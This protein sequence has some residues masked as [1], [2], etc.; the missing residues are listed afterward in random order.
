MPDAE[1]IP[2][3]TRQT[4][5]PRRT[6]KRPTNPTPRGLTIP[7]ARESWELALTSRG[8]SAGTINSYAE[9]LQIFVRWAG[10]HDLCY[11]PSWDPDDGK[12]DCPA[13]RDGRP[14]GDVPTVEAVTAEHVRT[15]LIHE[16]LRTSAG[17]AHKH[18]RNLRAF[19]NWLIK[20]SHVG[21]PG[22]VDADDAPNPGKREFLPL[23]D[24]EVSKLLKACKGSDFEARRDL[25]IIR[26]L[27]D[28]GPRL[29]GLVG[30]R[31]T[32]DDK[33][34]HDVQLGQYRIRI[35]LKGGDEY[36]A[37]IGRKAAADIDRY[38]RTARAAHADAD[39]PW[40]WLGQRG[41][42]G[43]T[44]VHKMLKRR[45][46][47]AGVEDVH[48]HRFRRTSSTMF[49]DAG[50]SETDAMHVYGWKTPDMVR[51]YTQAT[52]KERARRA[53]RRHAPGDRF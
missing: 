49:L 51:H 7:S 40:L 38:I 4:S 28:V 3:R 5:T 25:A 52:A 53:H 21:D 22:P 1:I 15:F 42:F 35:H 31:Y 34:T 30:I 36:W 8:R 43:R 45:G 12:P 18:F 19:F 27:V 50:G 26:L 37:P 32:P 16:R 9:T 47:E 20:Q 13:G 14:T 11:C 17:N 6:R 39:E 33:D 46:E 23:T 41:G 48:A 24:D 2:L 44:G 29:S 10:Q